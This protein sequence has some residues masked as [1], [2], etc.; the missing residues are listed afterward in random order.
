[1]EQFHTDI[2]PQAFIYEIINNKPYY[3]NNYKEILKNNKK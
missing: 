3:Y 1:M 2:I